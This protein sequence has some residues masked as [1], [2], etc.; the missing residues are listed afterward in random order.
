MGCK[1]R[2]SRL[3]KLTGFSCFSILSGLVQ[4]GIIPGAEFVQE[5]QFPPSFEKPV[6]SLIKL[7][8]AYMDFL[9]QASPFCTACLT[10]AVLDP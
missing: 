1:R 3:R 8:G 2:M 7:G 5:A 4:P 10:W 9:E 6:R